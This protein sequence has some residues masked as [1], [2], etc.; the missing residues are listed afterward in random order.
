MI[1][2]LIISTISMA[3][4]YLCYALFLKQDLHF[5]L[6]RAYLLGAIATSL[7][8]PFIPAIG[9]IDMQPGT[10]L[11]PVFITLSGFDLAF[12]RTS[13]GIQVS[14]LIPWVY[15]TVSILLLVRLAG[16]IFV[17]LR[18]RHGSRL[19]SLDGI[20]YRLTQYPHAP[21]SFFGAIYI[22]SLHSHTDEDL[23]KI[24]AHESVHRVQGHS[25]DRLLIE[26]LRVVFWINPV[27]PMYKKSLVDVHEFSADA[28]AIR[29][30]PIPAYYQ[31]MARQVTTPAMI[32]PVHAFFQPQIHQRMKM[33]QSHATGNRWKYLLF[34]PVLAGLVVFQ[35]C[36]EQ[37]GIGNDDLEATQKTVALT[38]SNPDNDDVLM[39]A[40][41]MPTYPGCPTDEGETARK[42]CTYTQLATFIGENLKYPKE[43]EKKGIEGKA[44][45]SFIV[46]KS[47]YVK[48][49]EVVKD[50]GYGMGDEALRV[51]RTLNTEE[52]AWTPGKHHGKLVSVQYNLPIQFA[53][54]A[55]E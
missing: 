27:L 44:V 30:F 7:C 9:V 20:P 43:A 18:Y 49:V 42:Q 41:V 32:G 55:E 25:F 15:C 2:Y 16:S 4:F 40:E 47:G 36:K 46:D 10:V 11:E 34:F 13:E 51:L 50:P 24:L 8:I 17:I 54:P 37:A 39:V 52:G 48:D 45:L 22:S 3:V 23:A 29:G 1:T 12:E 33:L 6:S 19:T 53:L 38:D 5:A 28:G 26:L 35:A 31:V 14:D 21:F